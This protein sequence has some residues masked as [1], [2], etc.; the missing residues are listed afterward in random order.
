MFPIVCLNHSYIRVY[1]HVGNVP[2]LEAREHRDSIISPRAAAGMN[3]TDST[4]HT[5]SGNRIRRTPHTVAITTGTVGESGPAG[6]RD[7]DNRV[8]LYQQL[9]EE[10]EDSQVVFASDSPSPPFLGRGSGGGGARGGA[11]AVSGG[12]GSSSSGLMFK[13]TTSIPERCVAVM[14]L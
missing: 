6:G 2:T 10:E 11:T 1:V 4:P 9:D 13:E 14:V 12:G 5:S 8:L 7:Q 3:D